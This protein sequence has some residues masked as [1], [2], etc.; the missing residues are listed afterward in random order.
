MREANE[1]IQSQIEQ[2]AGQ[3]E[4]Q[5]E[6]TYN[7]RRAQLLQTIYDCEMVGYLWLCP[8]H[9]AI[10]APGPPRME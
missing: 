9:A 7:V 1:K 10:F 4:R 6:N 2:Q 3:I 8:Q 5:E